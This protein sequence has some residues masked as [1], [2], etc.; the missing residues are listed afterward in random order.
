MRK[1]LMLAVLLAVALPATARAQL[2]IAFDKYHSFAEVTAFLQEA[3]QKYPDIARLSSIG[4][5]YQGR[6]LWLLE[7]TNRRTGRAEEKPALYVNGCLDSAEVVTTE[8]VLY[9][10][11]KLLEGYGKDR[12]ITEIIDSR[13]LYIVPRVMP[14]QAEVYITTPLRARSRSARPED[15]DGDGRFDE[16]ADDDVDGDGHIVQMRVKDPKGEWTISSKDPRLMVR[17]KAGELEGAFYRVLVEGKDDDGDGRYNEDPLGGV[18]PNRNYPGNWKPAHIQP[19]AGPYPLYVQEVRAE[20][21]F[22]E[23][24][25]NIAAYVNHHS[26]GG[27]VLRPSTTHEDATVPAGD[28]RTLKTIAAMLLDASGYWLA[29]SVYDWRYPPGTPDTKPGQTWRRPDGSLANDPRDAAGG[30]F[31]ALASPAAAGVPG[32]ADEDVVAA[33]EGGE[34]FAYHAWG[35]SIEFTYEI[36]GIISYASEQWRVA[37]DHDLDRDG[38]ITDVEQLAW[39]DKQFGGSLF[40]NWK[41]FRHPQLGE[42]EIGGWKKNST[43]SPPPGRY[44][45]DESERQ[46]QFNLLMS[47]L[48]PRITISELKSSPLGNGLFKVVAQ[49]ENAGYIPTATE[50]Q[51]TL[52]RIPAATAVLTGTNVEVLGGGTRQEIGHLKGGPS[53]PVMAEWVVRAAGSGPASVTVTASVVTGGRAVKTVPLRG[54]PAT[55]D[56]R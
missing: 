33:A 26:S 41:P 1:S 16:D 53:A 54:T 56:A 22:L 49:I 48:L 7:I 29:T 36:L 44:L 4:K 9:T 50:M 38:V 45:E 5:S 43:S 55:T 25:P 31:G 40:V 13:A 30:T 51:Q 27:V 6:D 18:D 21:E 47:K 12:G 24:H 34:T 23:A 20:V 15:D 11:R 52:R 17:R 2:S 32:A 8:G 10:I 3:A 19:N 28:L 46:F 37:F 14:D 39:N 35:G 42:I